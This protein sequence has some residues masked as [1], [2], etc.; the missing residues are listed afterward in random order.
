MAGGN[1]YRT[2]RIDE[3]KPNGEYYFNLAFANSHHD[4][5]KLP[6]GNY[7]TLGT[8]RVEKDEALELGADPECLSGAGT[9]FYL[10]YVYEIR[11]T[12]A[13][14]GEVVWEWHMKDHL[15]QDL[16]SKRANY[17]SDV[18]EHPEGIDINYNLCD[19]PITMT[20]ANALSY[21]ASLD[22]IMITLRHFSEIWIIDHSTT[23][24]QARENTGGNSG[25]GGGLL[26]RWGNP[27]AYKKGT[28]SDQKLFFPHHGHWIPSG[29]PGAGNVLIFNNGYDRFPGNRFRR[30]FS[31]VDEIALPSSGY[32]YTRAEN[33]AYGPSTTVWNYGYKPSDRF[34]ARYVSGAHRLP[35]GNTLLADGPNK[36]LVEVT[37]SGEKVWEYIIT[38][39]VR[40]T[41][42]IYRA[43]KYPKNYSGIKALGLSP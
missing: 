25:K 35:N 36:R 27:R 28:T 39:S 29:L 41:D 30:E 3:I 34:S 18:S 21:N 12:G 43:I 17:V 19:V 11:R 32:N 37:S 1:S 13:N 9:Y 24:A 6:N 7:L 5:L 15:I 16:S 42:I 33:S 23:T 31:T 10:D 26:Y 40:F 22:Q 2:A 38:S 20:H 14:T 4:I 8:S